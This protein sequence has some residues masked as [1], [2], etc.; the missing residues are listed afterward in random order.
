MANHVLILICKLQSRWD[1]AVIFLYG[2]NLYLPLIV[3]D[4]CSQVRT[5]LDC[6]SFWGGKQ[7]NDMA[8]FILT[9]LSTNAYALKLAET[10][11]IEMRHGK[12]GATT[13]TAP[14][15]N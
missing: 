9:A 6:K 8:D 7:E 2:L 10:F 4:Q 3:T 14:K 5:A 13:C 15:K 11:G 1:F 12:K